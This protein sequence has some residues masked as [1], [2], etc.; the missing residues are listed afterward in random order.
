MRQCHKMNRRRGERMLEGGNCGL[1][2][3]VKTYKEKAVRT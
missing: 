2:W 1:G 3:E